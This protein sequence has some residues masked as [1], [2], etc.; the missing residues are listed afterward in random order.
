MQLQEIDRL[1]IMVLMDNLS[2]PFTVSHKNMRWNEF[3]Y[4]FQV[5]QHKHYSGKHYCRAC[6]GL[7]FLIRVHAKGQMRTF[8]FDTGPDDGLI[9]QNANILEVDL[10]T[11]EAIVVSHGHNDHY[12]GLLSVL[13]EI[14]KEGLPVYVHPE[15]YAP[16][17]STSADGGRVENTYQI[18]PDLIRK[19]KGKVMEFDKPN[20]ILDDT[21][22]ISGE[23]PRKTSYELGVPNALRK[24]GDKWESEPK[25]IDERILVINLKGKGLCVLTGCGHTGVINATNHAQEL[26]QG[27]PVYIVMGGFHLSGPT[28]ESR[29]ENTIDDFKRINPDYIVTGHCTGRKAQYELTKLYGDRHIPYGV[30]TYFNF[31]S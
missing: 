4:R 17:A 8:L 9:I 19:H 21:I 1:E 15:L 27:Y 30:G 29:I 6:N 25:V 23:V 20:T 13:D 11:V 2:D 3:Q 18:T 7:S 5:N 12:G 31:T 14:G 22:L 16:R 24:V 28:Y 26:V 10:K